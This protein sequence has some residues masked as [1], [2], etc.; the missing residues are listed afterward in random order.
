M[1]FNRTNLE[2]KRVSLQ[3]ARVLYGAFN[4]TNLELKHSK[5]LG[6]S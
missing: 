5:R 4:R 6:E 2:L 3:S 1:T